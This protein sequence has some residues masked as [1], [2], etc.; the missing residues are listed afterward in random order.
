MTVDLR[1]DHITGWNGICFCYAEKKA[2][3]INPKKRNKKESI[4][5]MVYGFL[6][7]VFEKEQIESIPKTKN[8]M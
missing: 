6:F 3:Q 4:D 7:I 1:D 2:D 8:E 5:R